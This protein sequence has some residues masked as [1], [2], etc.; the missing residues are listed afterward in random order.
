MRNENHHAD[1][2]NEITFVSEITIPTKNQQ[3]RA[4]SGYQGPSY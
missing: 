2:E 4:T 3:I 1:A